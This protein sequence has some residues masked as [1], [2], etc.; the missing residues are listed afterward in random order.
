M[1]RIVAV[2]GGDAGEQVLEVLARHQIAVGQ[3]R[4]AEIGQQRV[5]RPVDLHLVMATWH[6]HCIEHQAT[7]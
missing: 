6:L 2:I 1:R 7:P 4:P 5:A 3:R